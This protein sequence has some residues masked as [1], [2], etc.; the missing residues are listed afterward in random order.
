MNILTHYLGKAQ[1]LE[2]AGLPE[3]REQSLDDLFS[4]FT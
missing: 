2:A 4:Q 1:S 3:S